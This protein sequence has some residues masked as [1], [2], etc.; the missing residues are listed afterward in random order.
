MGCEHNQ[1]LGGEKLKCYKLFLVK[2]LRYYSDGNTNTKLI[3]TCIGILNLHCHSNAGGLTD[4]EL[5]NNLGLCF[6]L[7]LSQ[8]FKPAGWLYL[9]HL[10]LK[11]CYA[12]TIIH[13]SLNIIWHLQHNIREDKIICQ[14]CCPVRGA[15]GQSGPVSLLTTLSLKAS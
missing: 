8:S 5:S 6:G 15:L 14:Q 11:T 2:Y 13:A 3:Q 10:D 7:Y 4:S 1:W 9:Q 12:L